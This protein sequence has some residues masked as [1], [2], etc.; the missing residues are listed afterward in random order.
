MGKNQKTKPEP[1][2]FPDIT[3]HS[4]L[5][6]LLT[7][8]H[9]VEVQKTGP[10]NLRERRFIKEDWYGRRFIKEETPSI[11][12]RL[13]YQILRPFQIKRLLSQL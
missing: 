2:N 4:G 3:Q 5:Y 1:V 13:P 8:T 6:S 10:Q 11:I 7:R 12:K 9:L